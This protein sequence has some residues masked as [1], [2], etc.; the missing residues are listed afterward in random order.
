MHRLR[1]GCVNEIF[2]VAQ[3]VPPALSIPIALLPHYGVRAHAV[4]MEPPL[5]KAAFAAVPMVVPPHKGMAM[6]VP[7]PV[8]VVSGSYGSVT[9]HRQEQGRG[10]AQKMNSAT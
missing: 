8:Q 10:P 5:A 7:M 2:A 3:L 4:L 1:R 6:S 9:A